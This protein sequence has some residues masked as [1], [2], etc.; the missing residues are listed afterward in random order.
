MKTR[1]IGG[2]LDGEVVDFR[3][4]ELIVPVPDSDP[5]VRSDE[6]TEV[7]TYKH[8][9]YRREGMI[10]D[11]GDSDIPGTKRRD[12][13]WFAVGEDVTLFEALT[14]LSDNYRP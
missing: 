3:G 2:P 12:I 5:T 6:L 9:V 11:S 8:Y 1:A 7:S 10:C 13:V 14:K 4:R